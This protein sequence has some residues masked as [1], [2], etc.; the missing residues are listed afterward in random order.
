MENMSPSQQL[1]IEQVISQAKEAV[2]QD[3]AA[4]AR[5]LYRAILRHQPNH[6]IAKK[7]IRKLQK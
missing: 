2:R 7:D 4:V 5:R 6:S 1:T 3:N